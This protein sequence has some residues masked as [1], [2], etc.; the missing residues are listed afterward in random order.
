MIA[1]ASIGQQVVSMM[2]P[3]QII[4]RTNSNEIATITVDGTVFKDWESVVVR[5]VENDSS[6][7]CMFTCSEG[8]PLSHSIATMQIR[9]GQKCTVSLAGD[10]VITGKVETRQVAYTATAHGIQIIGQA[11]TRALTL[12]S[13]VHKTREFKKKSFQQITDELVKPF[14]IK[15]K[16]IG[17]ISQKVFERL[18]IAHG[19]TPWAVI[20]RL[21]R[22][23]NVTLGTDVD[24]SLTGRTEWPSTGDSLIEGQNIL[25][26][27]E[28]MTT[29]SNG[30]NDNSHFKIT[31]QPP[32]GDKDW[33]AKAAQQF[34]ADQFNNLFVF[35]GS[36]SYVPLVTALEHP[37]DKDDAQT[38]GE[39]EQTQ[40][41]NEELRVDIVVQGWLRP[42]GT[43]W[44]AGTTVHVKSPMLIVD[45]V[46]KIKEV[47]FSQDSKAGTRTTLTCV[48]EAVPGHK[49]Q[50][51][52]G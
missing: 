50:A 48:R 28:T 8:S 12:G 52:A 26:A 14:G 34:H 18:N 2:R 22:L 15:F 20:E 39:T 44:K 29:I 33:G 3:E 30:D 17:Q 36:G 45:E 42:S 19:E 10:L 4:S 32:T 24:G 5:D 43:L 37:G 23:R 40:R 1:A 25:E 6:D 9:P 21:A 46:L 31:Q 38:R 47:E 49:Y 51:P 16:P 41:A 7:Y 35:G 13:V 11:Y 27:R